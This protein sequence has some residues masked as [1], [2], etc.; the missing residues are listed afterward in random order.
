MIDRRT[1]YQ[2]ASA[3]EQF[4]VPLLANR[5]AAALQR[6]AAPSAKGRKVLDVGCGGQPLRVAL[7]SMGFVYSSVD[8]QQNNT[9]TVDVIAPIDGPVPESLLTRGPFDF[10]VCTEVLEHVADWNAC[11]ENLTALLAPGGRILITCPHFYPLHEIPFD[12]WR[13][14]PYAMQFFAQRNGLKILSQENA[15][16]GLDVLGTALACATPAPASGAFFS[17]LIALAFDVFRKAAFVAIRSRFIR[18]RVTT[19][20]SLYL[21]NVVVMQRPAS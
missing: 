9:E 18:S 17:K 21:S 19:K 4:I 16:D 20:G 5:I 8:V 12:Y 13:P 1:V 11:F 15:G 7:E 10:I 14:T 3:Q 2:P 6:F